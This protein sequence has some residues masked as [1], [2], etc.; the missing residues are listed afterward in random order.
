LPSWPKAIGV[1]LV[2]TGAAGSE[3]A[4]E[5]YTT[6]SFEMLRIEGG[7]VAEHWDSVKE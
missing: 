5:K 3:R 6:A 7:K 2:L 1:V 4:R